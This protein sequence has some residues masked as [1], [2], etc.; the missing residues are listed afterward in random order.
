[1]KNYKEKCGD[2]SAMVNRKETWV[3][4]H[5]QI[6]CRNIVRCVEWKSQSNSEKEKSLQHKFKPEELTNHF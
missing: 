6:P 4:N 3:C 2:C 5:E 1:M